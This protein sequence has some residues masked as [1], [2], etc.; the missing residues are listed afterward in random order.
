MSATS[1]RSTRQGATIAAHTQHETGLE[2]QA[3]NAQLSLVGL[4]FFACHVSVPEGQDR[5]GNSLTSSCRKTRVMLP[6]RSNCTVALNQGSQ[7]MAHAGEA[8]EPRAPGPKPP[9]PATGSCPCPPWLPWRG[10]CLQTGSNTGFYVRAMPS[11][12]TSPG[13]FPH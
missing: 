10:P 2:C 8:L 4:F 6:G 9:A 1:A 7:W 3:P 5:A 13:R 12:S 11:P